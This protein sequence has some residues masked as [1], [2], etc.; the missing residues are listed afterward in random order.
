MKEL[1]FIAIGIIIGYVGKDLL[2]DGK[3]IGKGVTEGFKGLFKKKE[4]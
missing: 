4:K 2:K 3:D 1:L